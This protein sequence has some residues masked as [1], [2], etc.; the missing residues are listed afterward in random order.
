MESGGYAP[1]PVFENNGSRAAVSPDTNTDRWIVL[2]AYTAQE[3]DEL[4]I[5]RG[6]VV[7][8][9]ERGEDGW[10][11]VDREGQNGLVPGNYLDNL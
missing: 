9:L 6:D 11:T 2:Y 5:R 4:S 8:V 3:A 1:L 7:Q 10:W